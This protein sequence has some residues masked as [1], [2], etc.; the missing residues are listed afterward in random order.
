MAACNTVSAQLPKIALLSLL[1]VVVPAETFGEREGE[2]LAL[3]DQQIQAKG[4]EAR[5][6][7]PASTLLAFVITMD[8]DSDRTK[9]FVNTN[10]ASRKVQLKVWNASNG[11]AESVRQEWLQMTSTREDL[12]SATVY[13]SHEIG[14]HLSHQRLFEQRLTDTP[15]GTSHT[16]KHFLVF[17]GEYVLIGGTTLL[18]SAF[19]NY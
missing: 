1:L 11:T 18:L 16:H 12:A 8:Q 14:C 6:G 15:G 13:R 10:I 5:E 7:S 17:E 19:I 2:K 4:Q 9:Q 3:V